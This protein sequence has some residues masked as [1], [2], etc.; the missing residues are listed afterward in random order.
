M[1]E[2]S[3]SIGE[4]LGLPEIPYVLRNML[5]EWINDASGDTDKIQRQISVKQFMHED[6]PNKVMPVDRVLWV[7]LEKVVHND[8]N[9]NSVAGPEMQ[10]LYL[11]VKN[12][13][14]TMP[15]VTIYNPDR[16]VF[17]IVDGFHRY[18]TLRNNPDIQE[19]T[20]GY[21][22]IVVID[23]DIN[24]RMASTVRHN[25]ARGKHSV[26]GMSSMIYDMLKNGWT[27]A[28][29]CNELG[30]GADE[31]V[32]MKH[33]TGFSKLFKDAEFAK[34]WKTKSQL[35]ASKNYRDVIS[36]LR[37]QGIEFDPFNQEHQD[38]V[39]HGIPETAQ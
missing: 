18:S 37:E 23:K 5:S 4:I 33:I 30:M 8:Y 16:D 9:P 24:D 29:I 32:R 28:E 22:P 7:P 21:L 26:E 36:H 14:Y 13:G 1:T 15:V 35:R 3:K 31:L 25:R 11:S 39:K 17:E 27:D 34:E 38:M 2:N 12:D 10:L 19:K 20:H 6:S